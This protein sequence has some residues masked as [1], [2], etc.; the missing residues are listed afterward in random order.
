M[1][2]IPNT[3]V[4]LATNVRDVL[5]SE[6]GSV[7]NALTTF[8]SASAKINK[9]AKYKPE[10]YKKDFNLTD[11]DR[12]LNDWGFDSNSIGFG[13]TVSALFSKAVSGT[14][15]VYVLP[16]GGV[17][18]PY[19][20]GDFRLY[21]TDAQPPYSYRHIGTAVESTSTTFS[22]DM[23]V[24]T[25]SGAELRVEDF[26]SFENLAG[27]VG[28]YYF[29]IA[30]KQN[31]SSYEYIRSSYISASTRP[32]DIICSLVFP[33][34]GVWQ[35]LF[36][37]GHNDSSNESSYIESRT[38]C[39]VLPQGLLTIRFD[40]KVLYV[41]AEMTSPDPS[42]FASYIS[43]SSGVLNFGTTNFTFDLVVSDTSQSVASTV[44]NFGFE[45]Y[46]R[47]SNG[48]I[49]PYAEIIDTEDDISYSG[50]SKVS[51]TIVNFPQTINL[52]DYFDEGDLASATQLEIRPV[53]NR[54][55]GSTTAAYFDTDAVWYIDI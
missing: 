3:N 6:G 1:A 53:M 22:Y 30:R 46:L 27:S 54:V 47:N 35:C 28:M 55:S 36:C 5:N 23:R 21:N 17:N 31:G 25:N 7:S 26:A 51:R 38:D 52:Y 2:V 19:R 10:S 40:H 18:S 48:Q 34:P 12:K 20:L 11:S 45:V 39:L 44:F 42:S 41:H 29:W 24:V 14:T 50:N 9:W 8:F 32:S 15:W 43:Y 4:N 49:G 16:K 37:V 33:E 13:S